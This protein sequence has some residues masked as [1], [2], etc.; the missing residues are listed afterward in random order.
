[1]S[2]GPVMSFMARCAMMCCMSW[3]AA[4]MVAIGD[5]VAWGCR[6]LFEASRTLGRGAHREERRTQ[7][8]C[9][10]GRL[11][12]TRVAGGVHTLQSC[13]NCDVRAMVRWCSGDPFL[14]ASC[15]AWTH[16]GFHRTCSVEPCDDHPHERWR[17]APV[18]QSGKMSIARLSDGLLV[19]IQHAR[20][21]PVALC[22]QPFA[23]MPA[24]TDM[25]R[26]R[27]RKTVG[28][29][30]VTPVAETRTAAR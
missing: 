3:V 10:A 13:H 23:G 22:R 4:A 26:P 20:N 8:Q 30:L 7:T 29:E 25:G 5:S 27:L 19:N 14:C 24:C 12:L 18:H 15:W 17:A 1:M 28:L 21:L 11:A 9:V 16:P 2:V 6:S